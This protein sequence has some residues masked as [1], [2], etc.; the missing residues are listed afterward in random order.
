MKMKIPLGA[1]IEI[2]ETIRFEDLCNSDGTL[3]KTPNTRLEALVSALEP[4]LEL[5]VETLCE[6]YSVVCIVT[7][8]ED[9]PASN[10]EEAKKVMQGRNLSTTL[11]HR[12]LRFT[13]QSLLLWMWM[14]QVG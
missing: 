10:R 5:T 7:G 6:Q 4:R 3:S 11:R 1:G 12:R 8:P 2:N 9:A 14:W 13:E